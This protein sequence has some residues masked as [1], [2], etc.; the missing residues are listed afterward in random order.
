MKFIILVTG[1]NCKQYILPCFRSL[2]SQGHQNW[3]A[4]FLSDGATDGSG[5]EINR[6]V[7]DSRCKIHIYDDNV[8]AAKRR[9]DAL[10]QYGKKTDIVL[11]L[12]MDDELLPGCLEIILKEYQKGKWM[13]YGNWKSQ[14]GKMLPK[15]FLDFDKNTHL[16]R[17]Y[18]K[19]KYRSTAPNTFFKFL[20]DKIP[21]IDFQ[22]DG[23]W[24][25]STT[26]IA[27]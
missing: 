25:D 14:S 1:W 12:G 17:D 7:T 9:Y 27:S 23:K 5:E 8:G 10:Q 20:F 13:T 3:E 2:I 21:A 22:L 18:R 4:V 15:G 16:T 19:V 26:E 11:L 6:V 24:I